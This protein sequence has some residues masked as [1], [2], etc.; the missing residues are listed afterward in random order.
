LFWPANPEMLS[1]YHMIFLRAYVMQ[2]YQPHFSNPSLAVRQQ[3]RQNLSDLM[4][5]WITM[6]FGADLRT[7]RHAVKQRQK[8]NTLDDREKLFKLREIESRLLQKN[9]ELL[10]R[11][12]L[13]LTEDRDMIEVSTNDSFEQEPS[14]LESET[15]YFLLR[16]KIR[17][18]AS[19]D[20]AP[21]CYNSSSDI[22]KRETSYREIGIQTMSEQ[23]AGTFEEKE[24]KSHQTMIFSRQDITAADISTQ[25]SKSCATTL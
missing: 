14:L 8:N 25:L 12:N 9:T 21:V 16:Q 15:P 1:G 24:D 11:H 7:M 23:E 2:Y 5:V 18:K 19:I 6:S 13:L 10:L 3:V 20:N 4:R 17:Y 22:K